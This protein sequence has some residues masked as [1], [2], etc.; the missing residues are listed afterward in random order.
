MNAVLANGADVNERTSGGQTPLILATIFGYTHLIPLLL[1][2][3]ADP[4][5][6]DNL[7]LNAIDWAQRRGA[8]EVLDV[9]S[10]NASRTPGTRTTTRPPTPPPRSTERTV[11]KTPGLSEE[12]RSRRWI[13][14][15]KQRIAEQSQREVPDAPNIFRPQSAAPPFEPQPEIPVE[16]SPQPEMPS[17]PPAQPEIPAPPPDPQHDLPAEPQ[18]PEPESPAE[19]REPDIEAA[20][21][22]V[23]LQ[24][25]SE[26]TRP[27]RRKR[28]PKCNA[29]YNSD[30]I[31]YCAHHIVP[32]VDDDEPP[33][34]S[35]PQPTSPVLFWMIIVGTLI[36]SIVGGSVVAAFFYRSTTPQPAATASPPTP[37][38]VQKGTPVVGKELEGKVLSL[39]IAE[40]PLNGQEAIPGTVTVRV[41]INRNG[42]V[43]EARASGG[44]W[45]LRGAASEAAMKS[46]F[47]PDK[48]R[49]RA[50]EGTISYT[51]EP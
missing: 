38:N 14:G 20:S 26:T 22:D 41:T 18:Q 33:V 37:R 10:N 21:Q 12:E 4:Q 43:T 47:A 42:Q 49:G 16:P 29:I 36:V 19:P 27:S 35:Q 46:T 8:T 32:L 25:T 3:G 24:T 50:T 40:C 15:L 48:L 1:D 51:F 5:L 13:A 11:E 44:D 6:R 23:S 45:L 7:G 17:A 28:C 9:L 39:P 31:A 30:L 2:A 34:I